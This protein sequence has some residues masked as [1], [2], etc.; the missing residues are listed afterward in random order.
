[1]LLMTDEMQREEITA[2]FKGFRRMT[3]AVIV[4]TGNIEELITSGE[5]STETV[6][7]IQARL[8]TLTDLYVA[9]E[10]LQD[11]SLSFS[12]HE[13]ALEMS[14]H[15]TFILETTGPFRGKKVEE[16]MGVILRMCP[17]QHPLYG[18]PMRRPDKT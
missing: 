7:E 12:V 11:C 1:M 17:Y 3:P 9:L 18:I 8:S 14:N 5:M 16:I 2:L 15:I 13:L 4:A 6:A 10:T